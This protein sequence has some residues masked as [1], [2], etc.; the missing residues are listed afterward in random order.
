[1]QLELSGTPASRVRDN[2]VPRLY[3][4]CDVVRGL[5]QVVIAAAEGAIA[6]GTQPI[7]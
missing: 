5:N 1:M 6:T 2:S 4:V 7:T 3:A